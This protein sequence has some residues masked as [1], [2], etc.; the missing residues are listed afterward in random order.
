MTQFEGR[1]RGALVART[2]FVDPD[3]Q[4]D[5]TFA[6]DID[7]RERRAPIHGR[8]PAGVAMGQD[9]DG[10]TV[11][12]A[13]NRLDDIGPV[14]ADRSTGGDILFSHRH[15]FLAGCFRPL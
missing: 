3:V 13:V 14:I 8:Q 7:R 9:V 2:G 10:P 1:Q 15:R 11:L 5:T 6:G 4:V 12:L